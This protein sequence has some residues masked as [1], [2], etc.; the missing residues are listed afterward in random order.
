[1]ATSAEHPTNLRGA[2]TATP[3]EG[4]EP[5]SSINEDTDGADDLVCL[6]HWCEFLFAD[7]CNNDEEMSARTHHAME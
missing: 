5:P 4:A 7:M 2:A 6:V 3:S 1:M